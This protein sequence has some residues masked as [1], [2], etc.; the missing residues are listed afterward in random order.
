MWVRTDVLFDSRILKTTDNGKNRLHKRKLEISD[1]KFVHVG[2]T[3]IRTLSACL[4]RKSRDTTRE[5]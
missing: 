5:I 2:E 3:Y 1:S 4:H